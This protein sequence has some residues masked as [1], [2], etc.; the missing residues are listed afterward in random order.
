VSVSCC[1]D[2][3]R[4]ILKGIVNVCRGNTL[5]VCILQTSTHEKKEESAIGKLKV[6]GF[7]RVADLMPYGRSGREVVCDYHV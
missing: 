7:V 1:A 4:V 5:V 6:A 3:K 2:G